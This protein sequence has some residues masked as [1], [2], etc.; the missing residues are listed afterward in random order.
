M[1]NNNKGFSLVELIVVIAIMAI[2]AAVAVVGFSVY[3]PKAQQAG[4]KQ[5]ISDIEDAIELYYYSNPEAAE[6]GYLV[7]NLNN[8]AESDSEFVRNAMA[9][10]YGENWESELMLQYD[11]WN[12]T[13]QGSNFYSEENGLYQL[14]GTVDTLTGALGNF[15][16]NP[17]IAEMLGDG[18]FNTYMTQMGADSAQAKADAAVFYVAD[19]TANL[20]P[21]SMQNAADAVYEQINANGQTIDVMNAMKSE[22]GDSTMASAATLYAMAEGYA[23]YCEKN[24]STEQREILDAATAQIAQDSESYTDTT[25]AFAALLTAFGEMGDADKDMLEKYMDNS[26]GVSP[27]SQDMDAYAEAMKTVSSSKNSIQSNNAENGKQLG[28]DGYFT[29]D[30]VKGLVSAY[31]EGGVFVYVKVEDTGIKV[32]TSIDAE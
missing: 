25:A 26:D 29:N 11:G 23:T 20:A 13:F 3:I 32:S 31:S 27:L 21:G 9:A 8:P 24:G 5:M 1:K 19:L 16:N 15:L 14:L 30:Y 18:N 17:E 28:D 22:L 6:N 10:A 4:D 7:L 2:L 12:S